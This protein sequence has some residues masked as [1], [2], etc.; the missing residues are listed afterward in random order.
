MVYP[1]FFESE[2][3]KLRLTGKAVHVNNANT[4]EA[5]V[6]ELEAS[7]GYIMIPVYKNHTIHTVRTT[8]VVILIRDLGQFYFSHSQFYSIKTRVFTG[9]L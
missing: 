3:N 6:E 4:G 7:L 5:E 9:L 1:Y 2:Y 8:E